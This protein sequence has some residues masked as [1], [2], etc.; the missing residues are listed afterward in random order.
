MQESESNVLYGIIYSQWVNTR[1]QY[2]LVLWILRHRR[3]ESGLKRK[4]YLKQQQSVHF[5]IQYTEWE[6]KEQK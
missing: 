1:S 4:Q 2:V 6:H 3:N 5:L